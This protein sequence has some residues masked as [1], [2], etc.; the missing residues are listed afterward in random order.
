MHFRNSIPPL[1]LERIVKMAEIDGTSIDDYGL[2]EDP[3]FSGDSLYINLHLMREVEHMGDMVNLDM[4]ISIKP[5]TKE[6]RIDMARH[7]AIDSSMKYTLRCVC[8]VVP[9][10]M[11][12]GSLSDTMHFDVT[13]ESIQDLSAFRN[14][15][16]HIDI[17]IKR[18]ARRLRWH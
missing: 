2:D 9:Y 14:M 3:Q 5:F 7:L 11:G 12:E 13:G 6:A 10:P 18:A 15:F 1:I 8:N 16:Q 17:L 4:T